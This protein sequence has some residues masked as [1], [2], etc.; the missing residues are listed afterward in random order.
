MLQQ[1]P[2][3]R[4]SY[5]HPR[6]ALRAI[7]SI[8]AERWDAQ[9]ALQLIPRVARQIEQA[10]DLSNSDMFRSVNNFYNLV[11]GADLSL[12]NDAKIKAGPL[13]RNQQCRHLWIVH[14]KADAVTGNAGLGHLQQRA[15]NAVAIAD[16]HL[17]V[18]KTIDGQVFAEVPIL[19]VWPLEELFPVPVGVELIHHDGAIFSAVS[20]Q[21]AL[22]IA[23]EVETA[24][25]DPA[26]DR[27]LEDSGVYY[28]AL[29]GDIAR[30]PDT[31]CDHCVHF[32]LLSVKI[33]PSMMVRR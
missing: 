20:P 21:V 26:G 10:I 1:G 23:I 29:P 5:P 30:E 32:V 19:E 2:H 3:C 13:M 6:Q 8:R 12:F 17:V 22:P 11:A 33:R 28:F 16:A 27:P 15:A 4:R 24:R 25:H 7:L 14:A 9:S 18:G 31:D